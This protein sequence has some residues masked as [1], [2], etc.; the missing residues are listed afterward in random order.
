MQMGAKSKDR[1]RHEIFEG[2]LGTNDCD[3]PLLLAHLQVGQIHP[4]S[5]IRQTWRVVQQTD[6]NRIVV[7]GLS[8][9]VVEQGPCLRRHKRVQ[10]YRYSPRSKG[11][12]P[13][14]IHQGWNEMMLVRRKIGA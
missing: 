12:T 9:E 1:Y 2:N 4:L 8:V 7:G 3:T 10:N 5:S 13:R 11:Q 6:Y 14:H